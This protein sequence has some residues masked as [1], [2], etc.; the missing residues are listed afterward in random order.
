L[1]AKDRIDPAGAGF[2]RARGLVIRIEGAC[3]KTI[4]VRV[5]ALISGE[6]AKGL[7]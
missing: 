1:L 2:D 7:A 3:A 4:P 5:A 6:D